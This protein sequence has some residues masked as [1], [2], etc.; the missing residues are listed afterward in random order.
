MA[1]KPGPPAPGEPVEFEF[2]NDNRLSNNGNLTRFPQT[3]R[4]WNTFIVELQKWVKNRTDGFE[5]TFSG[6]SA[7]PT[8]PFVWY[9]RYGQIVFMEFHFTTGTSD[10]TDF[11]IT[12]LPAEI[13]PKENVTVMYHNAVDS[14][15]SENGPHLLLVNS[16]STLDFTRT[17]A[18]NAW[19]A[20]GTKGLQLAGEASI[21]YMLRSPEK[22]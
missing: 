2:L 21:I 13:T 1:T 16:D 18:G 7:D 22:L 4:Q 6:F 17:L 9:Q 12:N 11:S 14:S 15:S 19:T 10:A 8:T 5:P 20:S 3:Q